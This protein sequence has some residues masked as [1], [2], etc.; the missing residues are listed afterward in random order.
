MREGSTRIT[1]STNDTIRALGKQ[2]WIKL[3]IFDRQGT[4]SN[5]I[6]Q[7]P[8]LSLTER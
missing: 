6:E 1:A 8:T 2:R 7:Q 3:V 4:H 5:L